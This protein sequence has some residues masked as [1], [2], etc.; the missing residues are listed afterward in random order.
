MKIS[1]HFGPREPPWDTLE[2]MNTETLS[3][4][5]EFLT[6]N[7]VI[8]GFGNRLWA[9][10]GAGSI[11]AEALGRLPGLTA[12]DAGMTPEN[13]LE[14]VARSE[15]N[16]VLLIDATDFGGLA[17]EMKLIDPDE[18]AQSGLSTHSGSPA[19]LA[20]YLEA[21][22]SAKV[23]LLAIQPVETRASQQLSN[24]VAAAIKALV[25][26]LAAPK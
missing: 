5:S 3:L 15:P 21:R 22:C 1:A 10:D 2:A 7:V 25:D 12:I 4:L 19:M 9:D 13:Y 17:G 16:S 24:S 18:L 23:A 14:T 8:L 26:R 20:R 6:E 11:A